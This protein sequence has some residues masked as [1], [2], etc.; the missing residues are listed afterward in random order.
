MFSSVIGQKVDVQPHHSLWE[1]GQ[2]GHIVDAIDTMLE[3][4]LGPVEVLDASVSCLL[5]AVFL[6]RSGGR[7][8]S[9]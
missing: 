1:F 2:L 3:G 6:V 4:C 7:M 9:R 5:A 8:P